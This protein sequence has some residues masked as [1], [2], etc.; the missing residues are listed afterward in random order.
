MN[1]SK[2]NWSKGL[3]VSAKNVMSRT[4]WVPKKKINIECVDSDT[5]TDTV[6]AKISKNEK[7]TWTFLDLSRAFDT[8]NHGFLLKTNEVYGARRIALQLVAIS[9]QIKKRF[10]RNDKKLLEFRDINVGVPQRS[11]LGPLLF[12]I[13]KFFIKDIQ[14]EKSQL[15]FSPMIVR[16][17]HLTNT[18]LS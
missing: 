2:K 18:I 13:Y 11:V 4:I 3:K 9:L 10:V 14:Y 17:W 8:V 5:I 15:A 12:L 6:R 1:F 7:I 16:F